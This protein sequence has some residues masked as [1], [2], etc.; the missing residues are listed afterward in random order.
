MARYGVGHGVA[1]EDGPAGSF[2]RTTWVP[3][4]RVLPVRTRSDDAVVT[5]MDALAALPDGAALTSALLPLV[6]AYGGWIAAQALVDVGGGRR[7][8]TRDRLVHEA[9]VARDRI[10]EGIELLGRDA[11][12]RKAFCWMNAA[13]AQAARQRSPERYAGGAVPSWRL[14]QLAFVLLNVCGIREDD[15]PDRD[16]VELIFFPT[17]GGKTEAY[18]GVIGFTLLLRRLHGA[19]RPDGGLGVA[20]ALAWMRARRPAD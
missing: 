2:V 5:S 9:G 10:R 13:M 12:A 3:E 19:S 16:R 7:A 18:L 1:V 8:E 15:H 17:G 14:F 6:D 11:Q 20:V 4:G